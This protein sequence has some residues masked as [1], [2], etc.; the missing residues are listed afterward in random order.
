MPEKD[1]QQF[2]DEITVADLYPD[3]STEQ[4]AEAKY[5]MLRYLAIVKDIFERIC[6]ENPK[7]LTELER[8]AMLRKEGQK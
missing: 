2:S 4:Q 8:R 6:E 3:L 7:L 1:Y 5:R